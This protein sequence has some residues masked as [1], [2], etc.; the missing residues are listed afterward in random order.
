M[1]STERYVKA[2]I[3]G[4]HLKAFFKSLFFWLA[5]KSGAGKQLLILPPKMYFRVLKNSLNIW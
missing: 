1:E 5:H 2:K 3:P 4:Y